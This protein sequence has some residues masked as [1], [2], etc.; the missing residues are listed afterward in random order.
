MAGPRSAT[1]EI[2]SAS[3]TS[4][5]HRISLGHTRSSSA[6]PL[7]QITASPPVPEP[8]PPIQLDSPHDNGT[9]RPPTPHRGYSL[10]LPS[11]LS[12]AQH[13]HEER[14]RVNSTSAA[15]SSGNSL[16]GKNSIT[17]TRGSRGGASERDEAD[18]EAAEM[19][20]ATAT[21]SGL[22]DM[23]S[24]D[25]LG[26]VEG[27]SRRFAPSHA[28]SQAAEAPPIDFFDAVQ[29]YQTVAARR[30]TFDTLLWSVPSTSFAAQAF[31]FQVA[32]AGDTSR[33]ARIISMGLSLLITILTLQLFTR[34]LQ[35]EAADH[36]WLEGEAWSKYRDRPP[37]KARH[38]K[39]FAQTRGFTWWSNGMLIIGLVALGVLIT[40]AVQPTAFENCQ[41]N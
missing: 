39:F 4:S 20:R 3:P 41:K 35:A 5:L 16:N 34:Q 29:V 27:R 14:R 22:R 12:P 13:A 37:E 17:A 33:S 7:P 2:V 24:K 32:L 18:L 10:A 31:L 36:A 23:R 15:S 9:P 40:S 21:A 30:A 26:S 8:V 11:P 25:T 1:P 38:F 19:G 6:P 28:A